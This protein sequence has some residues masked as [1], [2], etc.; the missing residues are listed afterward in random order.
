MFNVHPST[1]SDH[2][3]QKTT[4]INNDTFKLT[5]PKFL[6]SQSFE[7]RY[8]KFLKTNRLNHCSVKKKTEINSLVEISISL[9][10]DALSDRNGAIEGI[11][12]PSKLP[13]QE[14]VVNCRV[15]P[16]HATTVI[17]PPPP[18]TLTLHSPPSR[19]VIPTFTRTTPRGILDPLYL[20]MKSP[21]F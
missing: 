8:Q 14:S 18:S 4:G 5:A 11:G 13:L 19:H 21:P 2:T 15:Q 7:Q 1:K 17:K 3:S 20:E 6:K 12:K 10:F 16:R 9:N